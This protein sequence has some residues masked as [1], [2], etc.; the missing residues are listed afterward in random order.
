MIAHG[1]SND[2]MPV[3]DDKFQKLKNSWSKSMTI[4]SLGFKLWLG[5]VW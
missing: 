5:K 4:F 3:R 2:N 1:P